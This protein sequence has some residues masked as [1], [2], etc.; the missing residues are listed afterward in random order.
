MTNNSTSM[1]QTL[2]QSTG[3]ISRETLKYNPEDYNFSITD[4]WCYNPEKDICN[5]TNISIEKEKRQI[6]SGVVFIIENSDI[7]KTKL[8]VVKG[9]RKNG[10]EGIWSIPKGRAS[11][12]GENSEVCAIRE[13]YEETG[14]KLPSLSGLPM[15]KI[16]HNIYYKYIAFENEFTKFHIQDTSEVD[17]V[18]WKT[19]SELRTLNCNKDLRSILTYPNKKFTYHKVLF[20]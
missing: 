15:C 17:L 16:A 3:S 10:N 9:Q 1:I 18:E 20:N 19:I 14:I 7:E 12:E 2:Y 11:Y 8:L 5:S 6:R 4:L 13:V